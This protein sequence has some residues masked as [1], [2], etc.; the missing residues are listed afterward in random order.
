MDTT[1]SFRNPVEE[2]ADEF[3]Q[4][5]RNGEAPTIEEYVERYPQHAAEIED[6]FPALD[7]IEGVRDKVV[8][9][10]E[11]QSVLPTSGEQIG[12]Y[13]L[14]RQIGQGG[15]GVV[16][17]AHQQSLQRR[18]AL[19]V[20]SGTH[21][22]DAES[23]KRF[24]RESRAAANLQHA[25]IVPVFGV[26]EDKGNH[27]YVMQFV[28]GTG[29]DEIQA[30]LRATTGTATRHVDATS[31][32]GLASVLATGS[33]NGTVVDPST[34]TVATAPTVIESPSRLETTSELQSYYRRIAKLGADIADGLAYAHE[35]GV[36][37]RD[38]KPSNLLFDV[39]GNI[40]LTDFGLAKVTGEQNLTRTGAVLGTLRYMPPEGFSGKYNERGDVY[41]LGITLF[42]F[43]H[44]RADLS[45][46]EQRGDDAADS[47]SWAGTTE[48]VGSRFATRS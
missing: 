45:G 29:M 43:L 19:K 15:M 40:W 3:M 7:L 24:K 46:R 9:G 2:L 17:E 28:H 42:E 35:Q 41:G 11:A 18:V 16:F 13:H 5:R 25:N 8:S 4:R 6:L 36:L 23:V 22:R 33:S 44:P 20:L 10:S 31:V 14:I 30:E 12:D 26:G 37:H 21:A 34:L 32:S 48:S 27:Y 1:E 47:R 39:T 38:I